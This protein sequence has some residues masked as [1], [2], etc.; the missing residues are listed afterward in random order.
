MA[1][2]EALAF[3]GRRSVSES[4]CVRSSEAHLRL[5]SRWCLVAARPPDGPFRTRPP[6]MQRRSDRTSAQAQRL[7]SSSSTRLLAPSLSI[8]R[9]SGRQSFH[10]SNLPAPN[11]ERTPASH[12]STLALERDALPL[13]R[14]RI[15]A[16]WSW[17]LIRRYIVNW[18]RGRRGRWRTRAAVGRCIW[19]R[20]A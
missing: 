11:A 8:L 6:G 10:S 9:G 15:V 7:T 20:R 1:D 12:L 14:A 2:D 19:G 13:D 3:A 17:F 18:A 5:K 16:L 4:L